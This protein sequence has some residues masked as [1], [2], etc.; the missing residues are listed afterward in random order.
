MQTRQLGKTGIKTSVL[1]FGGYHLLE[2]PLKEAEYLLGA[3]LDAGGSYIETAASYGEGESERKIGRSVMHR[4]GEFTLVSKTGKRDKLSAAKEIDLSLK[5]LNT[6]YLDLLLMH[7]VRTVEELD[8]LL[9]PDGAYAAAL[10]AKKA[11]KIRHI[12]ISMHGQPAALTEAAK[13]GAFEAVMTTVNYYDRCNYPEIEGELLPLA[14][15][16][17]LGV[18]LMKPLADGFLYRSAE[19]ALR[20]AFTRP[21]SVVVAGINNLQML[22]TDLKLAESYR[23]MSAEDE[24]ALLK[25][26]AELGEYVCRQCGKCAC[27]GTVD[28]QE[29]FAAEGY[30]D[31]Q[32][33]RGVVG[34]TAEYALMERLRFW[35]GNE[36]LGRERYARLGAHKDARA[37]SS[38]GECL[39]LCPYGIDIPSKLKLA[40]YKLAAREIF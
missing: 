33:M 16:K 37:C 38:C 22:K 13:R 1:G 15:A 25:D 23:P 27:S 36:E 9:K 7:A 10:E 31:R 20:Y 24:A 4:R 5:N 19:Q 32:M 30:Y 8:T 39:K 28:I 34:N 29:V 17:G 26:A 14:N 18:I 35:F 12:G 2:I 40:D 6:D 11:G 21:V 3:Y